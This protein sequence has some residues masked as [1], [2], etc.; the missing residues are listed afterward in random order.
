MAVVPPPP[1]RP[2]SVTSPPHS[3]AS[4][5]AIASPSPSPAGRVPSRAA[6]MEALEHEFALVRWN[7]RAAVADLDPAGGA[8][9]RHRRSGEGSSA[10]RS[11]TARQARAR[12]PRGRPT[13]LPGSSLAA[14]LERDA[15][16]RP[17][18]GRQ[19]CS[20]SVTRSPRSTGDAGEPALARRGSAA[21]AHRP[22]AT[23]GRPR[24][25]PRR[26][27]RRRGSPTRAPWPPRAAAA[28]RSAAC[29]ADARRRR[30][31]PAV[32]ASR[33]AIRSVISLNELDSERCS[34]LPSTSA[35]AP[36]I[37]LGDATRHRF[38][39]P[40]RPGD[41][42]RRAAPPA[43][44]AEREH[45]QTDQRDRRARRGAPPDAPRRRSE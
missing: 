41:L 45:D 44:Q 35:R 1:S 7:P 11:R 24:R 5:R 22:C 9:D 13:P 38:E 14:V 29:A 30:R 27:R 39:S 4:S 28:A 25:S 43:E 16:D 26:A 3:R 17:R 40:Q 33:R 6:S 31:S 23:G 32:R 20:A 21:A 36:Q 15:R 10:A 19:R 42:A 8:G 34:R 12:G 18:C 2:S 37:A